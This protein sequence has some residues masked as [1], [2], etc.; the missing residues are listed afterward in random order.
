MAG[1]R[2]VLEARDPAVSAARLA[3]LAADD[4]RPVRIYVARH[5]RTEGTTLARLMADEDELVQWN[6][7][8]NPN[9]PAH[10]LAELA[11]DEEQKHGVKWSTSLHVIARH[12]HT[13]PGLRTHLLA[14]G[15]CTCPGNCFMAAGFSRRW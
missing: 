2:R 3:E 15:A 7:L 13:D 9:A 8:V 14:A 12:P 1:Y 5:P 4:V 6:A 10:A 11:V